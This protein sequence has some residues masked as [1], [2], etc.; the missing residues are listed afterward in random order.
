MTYHKKR[1]GFTLIELLVVIA[2]IAVLIALLLPAVQAAREAARRSQCTNN[3]KQIGL[4]MHNYV[5]THNVLPWGAGPWGWNDWSMYPMVL[6]FMEQAPLFNSMNFSCGFIDTG[7]SANSNTTAWRTQLA[8]LLCPSDLNRLT[9][10]D[11]HNNYMGCVGSAPNSFYGGNS[12]QQFAAASPFAGVF[13][14]VGTSCNCDGTPCGGANGQSGTKVGFSDI[15]D[16][17]SN[18]AMVSERVKGI[19]GNNNTTRDT[20]SPSSSIYQTADLGG[21]SEQSPTGMYAACKA[22]NGATAA[23]VSE[24]PSGEQ[25]YTGY[26]TD[27]RYNHVMPPNANSCSIGDNTGREAAYTAS[28]RHSGGVNTLMGDASVRFVKSS[29][30]FQTWWAVGTRAGNETISADGF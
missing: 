10:A 8:G 5:S 28:S 29:V 14:F 20:T 19:A 18:T 7:R 3:L 1:T 21:T 11:G 16:G 17:L 9:S 2:I 12:G 13:P 27:T 6:P 15:L 25:W 26:A 4:A 30:N 24:S 23:L 22:L